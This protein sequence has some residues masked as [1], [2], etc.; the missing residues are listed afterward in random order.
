[1]QVRLAFL[2]ISVREQSLACLTCSP[3]AAVI[4]ADINFLI[5]KVLNRQ[6]TGLCQN[7]HCR[8][9]STLSTTYLFEVM[10]AYTCFFMSPY[11]LVAIMSP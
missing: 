3:A 1:M 5:G 8:I 6:I 10:N 9:I 4:V 7:Y 11:M 2:L